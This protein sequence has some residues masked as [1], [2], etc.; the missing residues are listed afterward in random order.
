I[1][2]VATHRREGAAA[3]VLSSFPPD[4]R[5][6]GRVVRGAD[7]S[8]LRIA[9]GTDATPEER[10]LGEVNTSIY[11]FRSEALWPALGKL[12]PKNVQ[13]ELYLT[14]V[15]EILASGGE[16]VA[17]H[18]APDAN[19]TEGVNTRAELAH[20]AA[21]L[22]DRINDAHM[23]AGVTIVDPQTAWI[24]PT[25]ELEPDATVHPF[26]VLRGATKV[27]AWAEIHP[28]TVAIDA[29]IGPRANVGPFCYLRPGTVLGDS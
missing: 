26:T 7:G 6:Y 18:V 14:D 11:V 20:A 8:V 13:G 17:A 12:E 4:P 3:T 25:V 28:H 21:I 9:E 5:V 22:R 29:E 19:E 10:E 24:D 15:V 27:G 1:D 23:L 2:L 16:R